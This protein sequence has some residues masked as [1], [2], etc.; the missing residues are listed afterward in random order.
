M[1]RAW[2]D[3][4]A[5]IG[6]ASNSAPVTGET[7][8]VYGVCRHCGYVW[9]QE[10][11]L[12]D[13]GE[14]RNAP[15]CQGTCGKRDWP[16]FPAEAAARRKVRQRFQPGQPCPGSS[17]CVGKLIECSTCHQEGLEQVGVT[18]DTCEFHRYG[19]QLTL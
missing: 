1:P 8:T 4:R 7:P 13:L 19:H 15:M 18:C 6:R 3:I 5:R 9:T 14:G 11:R 17:P 16:M 12:Y 10:P 2:G